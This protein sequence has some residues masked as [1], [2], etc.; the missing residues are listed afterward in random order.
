MLQYLGPGGYHPPNLNSATSLNNVINSLRQRQQ[1][2][3]Q[4]QQQAPNPGNNRPH[5]P[6]RQA[7]LSQQSQPYS[8]PVIQSYHPVTA[9]PVSRPVTTTRPAVTT[10]NPV[11]TPAAAA[12]PAGAPAA[13]PVA[14]P[15][16]PAFN[17]AQIPV[18]GGVPQAPPVVP[19]TG[20]YG[21]V[22]GIPYVR[23]YG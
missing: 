23:T 20:P 8:P 13:A 9:N 19:A 15:V 21:P 17:A 14:T 6:R 3:Q 18:S 22:A 10:P 16:T 11:A 2:Q 1:P 5:P 12:T 4:F 7:F